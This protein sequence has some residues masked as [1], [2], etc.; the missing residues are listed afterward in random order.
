MSLQGHTQTRKAILNEGI[1][2]PPKEENFPLMFGRVAR[3]I[4]PHKTAFVLAEL[5]NVS[6]RAAKDWLSGKTPPPAW[7]VANMFIEVT[8]RD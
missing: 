6:D 1:V 5:A 2:L 3:A 7:V 8:R 4:W